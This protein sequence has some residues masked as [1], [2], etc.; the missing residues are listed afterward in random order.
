MGRSK[1][2]AVSSRR[3]PSNDGSAGR[4]RKARGPRRR[5]SLGDMSEVTANV[6]RTN[7]FRKV[8]KRSMS[9]LTGIMKS[10]LGGTKRGADIFEDQEQET[11]LNIFCS[12]LIVS[13][14]FT[15]NRMKFARKTPSIVR[16]ELEDLLDRE[17]KLLFWEMQD[18]LTAD[19]RKWDFVR[20]VDHIYSEERFP[21]YLDRK[22]QLWDLL[23]KDVTKRSISLEFTPVLVFM[24]GSPVESVISLLQKV[25]KSSNLQSI[26]FAG[27]MFGYLLFDIPRKLRDICEEGTLQESVT[28][29]LFYSSA[30]SKAET[31]K[32]GASL[33]DAIAAM[34][35]E[36]CRRELGDE[37]VDDAPS[38]IKARSVRV[39]T[40][41]LV[42]LRAIVDYCEEGD[43]SESYS[44]DDDKGKTG[45]KKSRRWKISKTSV[46]A[47]KNKAKLKSVRKGLKKIGGKNLLGGSTSN[48]FGDSTSNSFGGSKSSIFGGSA[49]NLYG[50]SDSGMFGKKHQNSKSR[51]QPRSQS[52][53]AA[54]QRK[55]VFL[56]LKNVKKSSTQHLQIKQN[57][58]SIE[59]GEMRGPS[60]YETI[61]T[62]EALTD[63]LSTLLAPGGKQKSGVDPLGGHPLVGDF[64][65]GFMQKKEPAEKPKNS[66]VSPTAEASNDALS[67]CSIDSDSDEMNNSLSLLDLGADDVCCGDSLS[68]SSSSGRKCATTNSED[69][70]HPKPKVTRQTKE[71]VGDDDALAVDLSVGGDSIA[72]IGVREDPYD[73]FELAP[74]KMRKKKKKKAKDVEVDDTLAAEVSSG[75]ESIGGLD[76]GFQDASKKRSKKKKK[77]A[78]KMGGD[79]AFSLGLSVREGSIGSIAT[80]EDPYDENS[81]VPK[82]KK[83]KKY[84]EIVGNDVLSVDSS[85]CWDGHASIIVR[86]D[87]QNESYFEPKKKSKKKK[88][89]NTDM[90]VDDALSTDL[91]VGENS[92]GSIGATEEQTDESQVVSRKKVKKKKKKCLARADSDAALSVNYFSTE[93]EHPLAGEESK[94]PDKKKRKKKKHKGFAGSGSD[95]A[96]SVNYFSAEE[97]FGDATSEE[98]VVKEEKEHKK[99][100]CRDPSLIVNDKSEI[101]SVVGDKVGSSENV[102]V[103]EISQSDLVLSERISKKERRRRKKEAKELA[104]TDSIGS[105]SLNDVLDLDHEELAPNDTSNAYD[106][107]N[108]SMQLSMTGPLAPWRFLPD[109][110][111]AQAA[112][113]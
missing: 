99:K 31:P 68:S 96:L 48:L 92:K 69:E 75:N 95:S 6:T 104:C 7:N 37:N 36:T 52:V 67:A 46:K 77:K 4:S 86:Q 42:Q 61:Q 21:R 10:V 65:T 53:G 89:K 113:S 106:A 24:E 87:S 11:E 23:E 44:S 40:S 82:K 78:K 54:Q 32:E 81:L 43:D 50:D 72:S 70:Q 98:L 100:K 88:K 111:G 9:G 79:G 33:T 103:E 76:D 108:K 25:R 112:D 63:L 39:V 12:D 90:K 56:K 5:Q 17:D 28:L 74:K 2:A 66:D 57:R 110:E 49:S 105:L 27:A 15:K 60:V 73:A 80:G 34:G 38:I 1:T 26:E 94:F 64:L 93:E 20:F 59:T 18:I 41:C 51:R 107:S 8:R 47:I 55:Q 109:Q 83:K 16:L 91:P 97:E 19:H 29:K 101:I 3:V 58:N 22:K 13:T 71:E 84:E 45:R 35:D 62:Q 102:G 30:D 14:E 85:K